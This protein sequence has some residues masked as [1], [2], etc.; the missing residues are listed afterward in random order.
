MSC[1]E[2]TSSR[3]SVHRISLGFQ[4]DLALSSS[5]SNFP[6]TLLTEAKST[7]IR[8]QQNVNNSETPSSSAVMIEAV[9]K[10]VSKARQFESDIVDTL[11]FNG[12]VYKS[13]AGVLRSI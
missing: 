3:K 6:Y 1:S 13:A 7:P 4:V 2:L 10:S 9:L 5:T 8:P 11:N 12:I